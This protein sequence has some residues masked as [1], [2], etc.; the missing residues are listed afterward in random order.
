MTHFTPVENVAS[1]LKHGLVPR[2]KFAELG[3][4]NLYVNDLQRRDGYL[5]GTS[6]SIEHPNI[7]LLNRWERDIGGVWVV[8]L[9][10]PMLIAEDSLPKKF[11]RGNAASAIRTEVNNNF[12]P[13]AAD[14]DEL[15]RDQAYERLI[16][17][18]KLVE[19]NRDF[20]YLAKAKRGWTSADTNDLQAEVMVF[21]V[22]PPRSIKAIVVR[23]RR[24]LSKLMEVTEK[25]A[26]NQWNGKIEICD[27]LFSGIRKGNV[28]TRTE[29]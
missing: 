29:Q 23:H 1:I 17:M 10:D 20:S 8:L 14:F 12:T 21:D 22:I 26:L 6:L 13:T 9:L 18:Q 16:K 27:V 3:I 19:D 7:L 25:S 11:F 24:A 2:A 4:R 28:A 15:F 5:N